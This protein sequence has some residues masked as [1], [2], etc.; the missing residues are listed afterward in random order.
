M[1]SINKILLEDFSQITKNYSFSELRNSSVLISGSTGLLG[2]QL[3]LF[4]D[5][6]NQNLDYNTSIYALVR[7]KD[8]A[9]R[10]FGEAFERITCIYGDVLNFP[11]IT[12]Q[13][14]YVIHGASI[15]SS[16]AF[17]ENPVE[18]I[19]VALRGTKNILEFAK[20]K[21]VISFIYL[22]S[23]E[24]YGSF[25]FE[26]G[27][28]NVTEDDCGYLDSMSVRSSYSE[29]KRLCETLC[30]SYQSEYGLGLKV[31]RLCQT[32]GYGVDYNDNRV[33]AQF[34]RSVIENKDIVLKTKGETVRN[35]CYTSDAISG[36]LTILLKGENGEAYNIANQNSTISIIDMA[37]LYCRLYP[38][39]KSKVVFEV[40]EDINKFGFNP[41]VKLQLDST[42]LQKL[43]WN[44]CVSLA[45]SIKRLVEYMRKQSEPYTD[46]A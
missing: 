29:G 11:E 42:K 18:V 8:K 20:K 4:L 41:T 17:V 10:I 3:V 19:D 26:M 43:G 15:T 30:K 23:L 38:E 21:N 6:L 12:N 44:A 5:Y 13:I 39:S 2:S 31:A 33:F 24:V 36:I 28:K 7:S 45:D 34:A 27:V 35:Y 14:D 37:E 1:M 9:F 22:S 16:K 40:S 32:F 25:P 46:N